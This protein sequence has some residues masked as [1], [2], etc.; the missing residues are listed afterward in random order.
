[1]VY[2]SMRRGREQHGVSVWLPLV[3]SE[4]DNPAT[5]AL[6]VKSAA[7]FE[8]WFSKVFEPYSVLGNLCSLLNIMLNDFLLQGDEPKT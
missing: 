7:L 6:V 1:M 2:A 5:C 4:V 8:K 3:C